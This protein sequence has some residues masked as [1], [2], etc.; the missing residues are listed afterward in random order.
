MLLY[1]SIIYIIPY[2]SVYRIYQSQDVLTLHFIETCL[3]GN[4]FYSINICYALQNICIC[5]QLMHKLV[6]YT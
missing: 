2:L 3:I 5:A 6:E 4:L 1:Y